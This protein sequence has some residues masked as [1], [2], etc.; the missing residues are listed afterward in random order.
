MECSD[1]HPG[2]SNFQ[3]LAT[4]YPILAK[5]FGCF[6]K[7]RAGFLVHLPV[8]FHETPLCSLKGFSKPFDAA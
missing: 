1:H 8:F 2:R 7:P 6:G 5:R 3:E 4:A